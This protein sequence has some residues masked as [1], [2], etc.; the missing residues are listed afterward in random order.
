MDSESNPG[1][2]YDDRDNDVK[3]DPGVPAHRNHSSGW[4]C[5]LITILT[6]FASVVA[7]FVGI[8]LMNLFHNWREPHALLLYKN[9]SRDMVDPA[10]VVRPLIDEKQTFDIVATVWLRTNNS[11]SDSTISTIPPQKAI[12]TEKVFQGLTLKD[13]GI[14]KTVNYKVPTEILYVFFLYPT[15]HLPYILPHQQEP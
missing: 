12:F 9:K 15:I 13:K 3:L 11:S 6:S 14:R 1:V 4:K 2:T 7:L 5:V 8:F 10:A